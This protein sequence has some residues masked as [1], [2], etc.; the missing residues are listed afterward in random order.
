[1]LYL[2]IK[3]LFLGHMPMSLFWKDAP[4]YIKD[5]AFGGGSNFN[6]KVGYWAWSHRLYD[7]V[8]LV[9]TRM[10]N[11]MERRKMLF[12]SGQHK[13]YVHN[14]GQVVV[15]SCYC[16]CHGTSAF[17][18]THTHGIR[19]MAMAWPKLPFTFLL[20]QVWGERKASG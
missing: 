19:S 7:G 3:S 1:M 15:A 11:R 5:R 20:V 2:H 17:P 10:A 13:V 9:A 6:F 16:Q 4:L 8:G 14:K 18:S 12:L